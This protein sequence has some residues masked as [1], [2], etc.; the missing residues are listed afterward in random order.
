MLELYQF[1]F[2]HYCIKVRWALEH[3]Q[4]A[5]R[6][7]NL[8]P[9]SHI[10]VARALA[11]KSCLPILVCD[12]AVVQD[13][14]AIISF[15]DERFPEHPLTPSDPD[16]ARAALEWEEFLDAEIGVPLRLWFY[17]HTLPDRARALRFLLEG[18][19]W[20]A[21]LMF[22]VAFP[23][24][25]TVMK[26][27]MKIDAESARRSEE[28]LFAA[29]DR[30]DTALRDREFLVGGRLSRADLTGCAL[31]LPFCRP[32]ESAAQ[33]AEILPESLSSVRAACAHRRFFAWASEIYSKR[34]PWPGL[35]ACTELRDI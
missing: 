5:Y 31:L 23:K 22:G 6:E 15:L 20:R 8:L 4:I 11:D 27:A 32:G 24:V 21:R 33:A 1:R 18:Q 34:R 16:E 35:S 19:P 9:G 28:R 7:R 2:S 30:L 14:T 13:S 26:R 25:R 10:K 29:L 12:G 3:K 17:H